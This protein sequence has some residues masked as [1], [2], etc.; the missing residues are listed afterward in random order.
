MIP[1]EKD[2]SQA[3]SSL[4]QSR[5]DTRDNTNRN[6]HRCL[7]VALDSLK[8]VM[9]PTHVYWPFNGEGVINLTQNSSGTGDDDPDIAIDYGDDDK[10]T[11]E[12]VAW[13]GSSEGDDSPESDEE[14]DPEDLCLN[15]VSGM[16]PKGVKLVLT[17]GEH[18]R[19]M[20]CIFAISHFI[21][22]GEGGDKLL[23]RHKGKT[24]KT[25]EEGEELADKTAS[26]CRCCACTFHDSD[27]PTKSGKP[28][29]YRKVL[30]T[31][32]TLVK[33]RKRQSHINKVMKREFSMHGVRNALWGMDYG[34]QV[35]GP[36][37]PAFP[38]EVMHADDEGVRQRNIFELFGPISGGETRRWAIDNI[39]RRLLLDAPRQSSR[40]RFPR[41]SFTRGIT[42]LSFLAA[43]ERTGVSLAVTLSA[44]ASGEE[45][46]ERLLG[47]GADD[48]LELVEDRLVY[49]QLSLLMHAFVAYGPYDEVLF[50]REPSLEPVPAASISE[51]NGMREAFQQVF[52]SD[53]GSDTDSDLEAMEKG[54]V[55]PRVLV[56]SRQTQNNRDVLEEAI[57]VMGMLQILTFNRK[58]GDGNRYPKFHLYFGS[59]HLV[60]SLIHSGD[61]FRIH[62]GISEYQHKYFCKLTG[63]T[64]V[65]TSQQDFINSVCSRLDDLLVLMVGR[66]VIGVNTSGGQGAR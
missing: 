51:F 10:I 38:V 60:K 43:H 45:D 46:R 64:A 18:Q 44:I 53:G 22:D 32:F 25:T 5:V 62:A 35:N 23:C 31:Y 29:D 16:R 57:R 49:L 41:V 6:Y 8:D 42:T 15:F 27:D 21:V 63:K 39:T 11:D 55:Q 14:R 4:A 33:E 65:K 47:R 12:D 2:R 30:R 1:C 26:I 50:K 17:L 28:V 34:F 37:S 58:S 54:L 20:N 56:T 9:E 24:R 19:P 7:G 61:G 59:N 52:P 36:Y 48:C 3:E 40:K 13:R 66:A